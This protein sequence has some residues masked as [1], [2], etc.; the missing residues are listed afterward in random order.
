MASGLADLIWSVPRQRVADLEGWLERIWKIVSEQPA[1]PLDFSADIYE[2]AINAAAGKLTRTL[3]LE[4]D[5][6]QQE[7]GTRPVP[8]LSPFEIDHKSAA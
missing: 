7:G 4:F 5:A 2:K 6:K 3:L 8:K 1:E